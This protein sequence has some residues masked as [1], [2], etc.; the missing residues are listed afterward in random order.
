MDEQQPNLRHAV[1]GLHV[2]PEVLMIVEM[3]SVRE[4][5]AFSGYH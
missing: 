2:L 1:L 4:V 5:V 3:N